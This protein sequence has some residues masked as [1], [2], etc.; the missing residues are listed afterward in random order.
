MR[1]LNTLDAFAV[2]RVDLSASEAPFSKCNFGVFEH[3]SH[4]T[5]EIMKRNASDPGKVKTQATALA[6][7]H[8]ISFL[9]RDPP[10]RDIYTDIIDICIYMDFHKSVSL[11]DLSNNALLAI[12]DTVRC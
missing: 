12:Q 9:A 3:F 11:D 1:F 10:A 6:E 2:T 8:G 4:L 5:Q 7:R